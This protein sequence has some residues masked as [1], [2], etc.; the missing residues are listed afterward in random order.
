MAP[1]AQANPT[2]Q[3]EDS[4]MVEKAKDVAV[5]KEEAAPAPAERWDPF[6]PL[7]EEMQRLFDDFAGR[8]PMGA[9]TGRGWPSPLAGWA[10]AAPAIDIVDLEKEV[11][12]RAELP[13]MEEK[14]IDVEIA[15]DTLTIRGEKKE[16]REEGE[17]EG[18]YYLSERRYGSFERL[19]RIPAGAD[20]DKAAARFSKGVLTVTFPKTDEVLKKPKKV[21]VKGE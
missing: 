16:E 9:F 7:R 12:V 11:Q 4:K 19:L 15:D 2:V 17:K 20:R 18:R 13:G 8:W 3:E 10:S 6:A 1:R 5:K 14:D 21:A